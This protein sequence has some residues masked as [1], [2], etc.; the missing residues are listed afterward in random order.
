[1][2]PF[3]YFFY[4]HKDRPTGNKQK[5]LKDFFWRVSLAGRYSSAVESKLAQD[6]KKIDMILK[7]ELPKYDWPIDTSSQFIKDNGWFSAGRSYVKAILCIYAHHQPKSFIDD[8]LVNISNYWLKQ[9][10]SKNYHHFF[11][12]A[13]LTG[14]NEDE[15]KINHILNITIVDDFLNKN[16]IRAKPPSEYMARFKQDNP[17]LN[18]TMKTH[19]INNLDKFGV[20]RDNYHQFFEERAKVV[21]KEIGRRVIKQTID[22]SPQAD[23]VDDLAEEAELE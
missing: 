5:Y 15:R 20:W 6:V 4:H 11:P 21:S 22:E 16:K 12:K 8:S 23:I 19:L 3:A 7:N 14:L 2:V 10:N 17:Q 9:A 1:M 18:E 13:Y